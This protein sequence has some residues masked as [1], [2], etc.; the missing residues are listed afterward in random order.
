MMK[1]KI[2]LFK[3]SFLPL[4]S[5]ILVVPTLASC[6]STKFYD[7]PFF[8]GDVNKKTFDP[9]IA[10][11]INDLG[12]LNDT[13]NSQPLTYLPNNYLYN[14]NDQISPYL[15]YTQYNQ[16]VFNLENMTVDKSTPQY[17][18]TWD[19]LQWYI[20]G[21]TSYKK[22]NP[23]ITEDTASETNVLDTPDKLID[24]ANANINAAINVNGNLGYYLN[25]YYQTIL[26]YLSQPVIT[27]GKN[28]NAWMNALFGDRFNNS[29]ISSEKNSEEINNWYSFLLSLNQVV[30]D[31]KYDFA[32]HPYNVSFSHVQNKYGYGPMLDNSIVDDF[33]NPL[34]NEYFYVNNEK[35]LEAPADDPSHE[36][37]EKYSF[38]SLPI[39]VSADS[40]TYGYYNFTKLDNMNPN[41]WL[42]NDLAKIKK[43]TNTSSSWSSSKIKNV[44]GKKVEPAS[45]T[46]KVSTNSENFV[47]P[48]VSNSADDIFANWNITP[49]SFVVFVDY[50]MLNSNKNISPAPDFIPAPLRFSTAYPSLLLYKI[51]D[52]ADLDNLTINDLVVDPSV[53]SDPD[54]STTSSYNKLAR[55]INT[56]VLK[57]KWENYFIKFY[58][59]D[60]IIKNENKLPYD[61]STTE[62]LADR[63][64]SYLFTTFLLGKFDSTGLI[65]TSI[66]DIISGF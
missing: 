22:Y 33:I 44:V 1:N 20:S 25:S 28:S 12:N 38:D 11:T 32:F 34:E 63:I 64:Y 43:A 55:K 39:L 15:G 21:K 49:N 53:F 29:F 60:G 31:G 17:G 6:S 65:P 62:N 35:N 40:L 47:L 13:P 42:I 45:L 5:L 4:L 18:W 9:A 14:P 3:F 19:Y 56:D 36:D 10:S 2:S 61:L 51:S 37:V 46:Y 59:T 16:H 24:Y 41:T 8:I 58:Q 23:N 30:S 52:T 57:R 54:S 27:L 66:T 50:T 48:S 26:K 7:M